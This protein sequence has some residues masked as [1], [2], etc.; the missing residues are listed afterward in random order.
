MARRAYYASVTAMDENLGSLIDKLDA[1]HAVNNTAVVVHSD[2]GWHLGEHGGWR[3]FTNFEV[4]LR[5]PLLV[6]VPWLSAEQQAN[7]RTAALVELVDLMPTFADLA[8]VDVNALMN[9]VEDPLEGVS[10]VPLLNGS[11]SV[12][13]R[14][15]FSQHPRRPKDDGVKW[16]SN[17][18]DHVDPSNF[19]FM[20]M[21]V[22]TQEWRL[23]SW[24]RWDGE[25]RRVDWSA[26][27]AVELYD[28]RN[29]DPEVANFDQSENVNLAGQDD[30]KAVQDDLSD[31]LRAH[32]QHRR[33]QAHHA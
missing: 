1:S 29:E 26:A 7:P 27:E 20:G 22:R 18:I 3:K 12:V 6:R 13:K 25:A 21:T 8:G 33:G 17:S 28:H 16:R 31:L 10:L 24:Y 32:F 5:V 9:R 15:A 11:R 19:T 4:A 14:A 30:Y 2:H 23:T